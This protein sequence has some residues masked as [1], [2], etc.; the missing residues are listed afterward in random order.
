MDP[1]G[2]AHRLPEDIRRIA[3]QLVVDRCGDDPQSFMRTEDIVGHVA[4]GSPYRI[5]ADRLTPF[6]G[7]PDIPAI[8]NSAGPPPHA[9][10][11]GVW[12][13]AENVAADNANIFGGLGTLTLADPT[14]AIP[15]APATAAALGYYGALLLNTGD[16]VVFETDRNLPITITSFGAT[17]AAGFLQV[18]GKGG[19]A[20]VEYHDLP[21]LHMPI[22]DT[23]HGHFLLARADGGDYRL[24]AFRIPYGQAIY[25]PPNVLHADPF[26]VGRYLVV[27]SLT[28]HYSTVVFRTGGGRIV[29][30]RIVAT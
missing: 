9:R 18:E 3:D 24:S 13:K 30:T 7:S 29:D 25:T 28:R 14:L 8:A 5:G 4:P 22:E 27:Y 19:G 15:E 26:L 23:A 21:H 6:E 12:N 1:L 16:P 20:F 17:Y 11:G 2:N 10:V